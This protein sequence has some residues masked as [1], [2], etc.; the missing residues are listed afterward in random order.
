MT[1]EHVH[2]LN[3]EV[4]RKLEGYQDQ[5]AEIEQQHQAKVAELEAILVEKDGINK[6]LDSELATEKTLK[7]ALETVRDDLLK[8]YED[9][10]TNWI[11][12][13]QKMEF[14]MNKQQG[15]FR[16]RI[17]FDAF[18]S[19]QMTILNAV[20]SDSKTRDKQIEI[21]QTLKAI[22]DPTSAQSLSQGFDTLFK[23]LKNLSD[24]SMPVFNN[25]FG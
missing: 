22:V 4:K 25:E 8:K 17:P 6:T 18:G 20:K 10:K 16:E 2:E 7:E 24:G 3:F 9:E 5:M 13:R 12:S 15:Q 1:I 21:L 19:T 23:A 11:D 14:K